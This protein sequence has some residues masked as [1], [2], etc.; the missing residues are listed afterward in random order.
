M[1]P[2][3]LPQSTQIDCPSACI[4]TCRFDSLPRTPH[5]F[6][7]SLHHSGYARCFAI[8]KHALHFSGDYARANLDLSTV[9]N[10]SF[11]DY[12]GTVT[13]RR[14]QGCPR[15]ASPF[16]QIGRAHV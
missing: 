5:K 7:G 12:D 11:A 10:D 4:Q 6:A 2:A 3:A 9:G 8:A 16:P 14:A 15:R 1:Q 13:V